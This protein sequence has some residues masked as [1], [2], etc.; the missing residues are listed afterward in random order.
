MV[1]FGSGSGWNPALGETELGSAGKQPDKGL[2]A[3][4]NHWPAPDAPTAYQA[5]AGVSRPGPVVLVE[6]LDIGAIPPKIQ[7]CERHHA[8]RSPSTRPGH[9][10]AINARF[11]AAHFICR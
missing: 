3:P 6:T 8:L 9:F 1:S 4:D 10:Q 11:Y 7:S 2:F 5:L